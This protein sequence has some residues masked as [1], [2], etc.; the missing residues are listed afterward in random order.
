[1]STKTMIGLLVL[2]VIVAATASASD[3]PQLGT[4]KLNVPKS[5]FTPGATKNM[6]VVYAAEG[7]KIK[8]TID[9][10]DGAGAPIH[11]EWTGKFDG[12][13]YPVT[14][15]STSDT[16]AYYKVNGQ[17]LKFAEKKGGTVTLTGRITVSA[18]GKTRTV[19][20]S[21]TTANPQLVTVAVYD[22]Q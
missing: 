9:G 15:S 10:V 11:N 14:G 4:W 2:V 7:D 20:A 22:K 8:V 18:D 13:D 6:T 12:N 1:M 16:R 17:T 5:K 21:T 3:N 19:N